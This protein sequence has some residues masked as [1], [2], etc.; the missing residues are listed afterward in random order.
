MTAVPVEP[1]VVLVR[2]G[3]GVGIKLVRGAITFPLQRME[4]RMPECRC[5][6]IPSTIPSKASGKPLAEI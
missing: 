5:S 6:G 4:L 1:R 3:L 2:Y